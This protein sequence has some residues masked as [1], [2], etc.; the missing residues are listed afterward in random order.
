MTDLSKEAEAGDDCQGNRNLP[1][2]KWRCNF[3][4]QEFCTPISCLERLK[5]LRQEELEAAK[6]AAVS[7]DAANI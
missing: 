5:K 4:G 7:V 6:I 2:G 1:K 3:C